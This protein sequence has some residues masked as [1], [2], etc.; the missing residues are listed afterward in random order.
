[1]KNSVI[2]I[3]IN[4]KALE[5]E[6]LSYL[7]AFF[8]LLF[9]EGY[10]SHPKELN[11]TDEE[12]ET[13]IKKEYI[14]NLSDNIY[15]PTP[16]IKNLSLPNLTTQNFR[17]VFE[18]TNLEK[19]AEDYRNIFPKGVFSGG[20]MVRGDKHGIR[21]KLKRFL[22]NYPEYTQEQILEATKRYVNEMRLKGYAYMRLAHYFIEKDGNSELASYCEL[23]KDGNKLSEDGDSFETS[24]N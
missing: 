12:I 10:V 8:L 24:L 5:D 16:K 4:I 15:R 6:E 17:N 22:E 23:V 9:D 18:T 1:M 19:F 14:W 11:L 13:L 21:K 20:Y 7:Q 3:Q 2:S